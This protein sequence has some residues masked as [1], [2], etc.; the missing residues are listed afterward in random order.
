MNTLTK[1][2][3]YVDKSILNIIQSG[4]ELVEKKDWYE[5]YI[6]KSD[7]SFW[8]LDSWDKYQERFFLRLNSKEDWAEFDGKELIMG[9]LLETSGTSEEVCAWKDCKNSA[10]NGLAYCFQH[11]YE[12]VGIRK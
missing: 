11:A 3:Y 2:I 7:N 8:R 5:L 12:E 4:F 9:L 6:N 10:I 1:R